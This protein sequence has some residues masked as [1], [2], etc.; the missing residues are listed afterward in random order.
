MQLN[1]CLSLA[2]IAIWH[3]P[4]WDPALRTMAFRPG[5]RGMSCVP[6]SSLAVLAQ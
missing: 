6:I 2:L 3:S 1:A 5:R 4:Y